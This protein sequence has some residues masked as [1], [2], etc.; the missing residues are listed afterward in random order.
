[1]QQ[2][3][4]PHHRAVIWINYAMQRRALAAPRQRLLHGELPAPRTKR[5]RKQKAEQP[6]DGLCSQR[7]PIYG[8]NINLRA[9]RNVCRSVLSKWCLISI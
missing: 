6:N 9:G 2:R 7:Y 5:S 4:I 1:M 3:L 8:Y